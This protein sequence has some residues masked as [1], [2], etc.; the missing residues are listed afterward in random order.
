MTDPTIAL[1]RIAGD[2]RERFAHLHGLL[3]T[4]ICLLDYPPGMRLS[5]EALAEEFGV[6]RTPLRRVLNRLEDEG[7]VNSVHGV[8]TIVTDVDIEELAQVYQL[9]MEL[10]ELIGRLS[11][12]APSS[13]LLGGFRDLVRRGKELVAKPDTR[14]FAQLNMDFFHALMSLTESEPLRDVSERLY[15]RTARIWL[16][17][18]PSLDFAEEVEVFTREMQDILTALEI[19]DLDA[20]GHIRRSHISMSFR[21]LQSKAASARQLRAYTEAA[22]PETSTPG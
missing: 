1:D 8:G 15:Y 17:S 18:I 11:P 10:A 3:R 2:A 22:A 13:E 21:R 20:A 9:R 6:S 16:K 4:R 12:V 5:E 14:D 7:L 19:S